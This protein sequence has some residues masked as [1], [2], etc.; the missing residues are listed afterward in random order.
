MKNKKSITG[1]LLVITATVILFAGCRDKVTEARLQNELDSLNMLAVARDS[2]ISDFLT[3]FNEIEMNLDSVTQRQM[4]LIDRTKGKG[5]VKG[6]VK[7]RINEDIALI[8]DLMERNRKKIES[9][10][11]NLKRTAA[12]YGELEKTLAMVKEQLTRKDYELVTLSGRLSM[13]SDSLLAL[14]T[15]VDTLTLLGQSQARTISDQTRELRT[16][17]YVIG[18]KKEL[19]EKKIIDSEGGILGLGKTQKMVEDV[20]TINFSKIDYTITTT[21]PINAKKARILTSHPTDSYSLYKNGN[22]E[23]TAIQVTAPQKFWSVSKY[24]VVLK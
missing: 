7:A 22:G 4:L 15:S 23:V 21:I 3:S 14:R 20:D 8:N 18:G 1:Y 9:L 11:K 16:A 6:S 17:Y 2:M 19:Q 13:M 10:T 12:K 5:D 24:L